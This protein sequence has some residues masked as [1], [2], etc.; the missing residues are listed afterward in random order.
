[1]LGTISWHAYKQRISLIV[2]LSMGVVRDTMWPYIV[3][4]EGNK[5]QEFRAASLCL[6]R[7]LSIGLSP[8]IHAKRA[9]GKT[10]TFT[11]ATRTR[12]DY[13]CLM[14]LFRVSG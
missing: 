1:M 10:K 4:M 12:Q 9:P 6:F 13:C 11:N 7:S 3:C 8:S 2:I 5:W 14:N